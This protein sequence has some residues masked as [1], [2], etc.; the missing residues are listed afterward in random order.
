MFDLAVKHLRVYQGEG[1]S[2]LLRNDRRRSQIIITDI[3]KRGRGWVQKALNVA[4][5][6]GCSL[7]LFYQGKLNLFC[8]FS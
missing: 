3:Y 6:N 7:L 2:N 1:I 8:T 5:T 4:L